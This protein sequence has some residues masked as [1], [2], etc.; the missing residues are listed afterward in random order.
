M[1]DKVKKLFP[2]STEA[3]FFHEW[4]SYCVEKSVSF[5]KEILSS[6]LLP[7]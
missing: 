4:Q 7:W 2:V 3:T 6:R 5:L 1:R